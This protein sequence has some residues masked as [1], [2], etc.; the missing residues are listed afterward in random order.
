MA[1][2]VMSN[3]LQPDNCLDFIWQG[4]DKLT[5]KKN[6]SDMVMEI[7]NILSLEHNVEQETSLFSN[8]NQNYHDENNSGSSNR[9]E[10]WCYKHDGTYIWTDCPQNKHGNNYRPSGEVN[11]MEDQKWVQFQETRLKHFL[12]ASSDNKV[13]S[14][15]KYASDMEE[16]HASNDSSKMPHPVTF[17]TYK[18]TQK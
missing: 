12:T 18:N 16:I 1:E 7:S 13:L 5:K 8:D 11:S 9:V 10:Q 2:E 14:S 4:Y 3:M 15:S 17:M 6:T